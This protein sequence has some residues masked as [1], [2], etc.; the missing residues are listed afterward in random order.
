MIQLDQNGL[1]NCVISELFYHSRDP[2]VQAKGHDISS[3]ENALLRRWAFIKKETVLLQKSKVKLN[4]SIV[5]EIR[6][7]HLLLRYRVRISEIATQVHILA[8]RV[9]D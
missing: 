7:I 9:L 2:R 6:L 4:G 1:G 8:K 5:F 3:Q